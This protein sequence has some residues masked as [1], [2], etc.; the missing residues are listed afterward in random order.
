MQRLLRDD[1]PA[2]RRR[3][4][5]ALQ[6]TACFASAETEPDGDRERDML[7]RAIVEC[8]W[9]AGCRGSECYCGEGVN[10]DTCLK[11][12]NEGRAQGKCAE[13]IQQAAGCKRNEP[14]GS[15]VFARQFTPDGV[16]E[17]ATDLAKCVSGDPH[18]PSFTIEPMCR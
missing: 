1:R 13:L 5:C 2:Q 7:C 17:R 6:L 4:Y 16:L 14:P 18:L 15:C 12:A 8:G 3:T 11:N 10:R 9:A